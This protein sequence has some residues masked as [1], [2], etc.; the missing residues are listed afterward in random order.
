MTPPRLRVSDTINQDPRVRLSDAIE[1]VGLGL[2]VGDAT[3]VVELGLVKP[4]QWLG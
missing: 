3:M 1:V 4:S 2:R